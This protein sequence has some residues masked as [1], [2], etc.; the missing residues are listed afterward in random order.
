MAKPQK[1][2]QEE[3]KKEL[4][5]AIPKKRKAEANQKED[6]PQLKRPP[7]PLT[8][9]TLNKVEPARPKA[10]SPEPKKTIPQQI[11][12]LYQLSK[13]PCH[14]ANESNHVLFQTKQKIVTLL[15]D[16]HYQTHQSEIEKQH[17]EFLSKMKEMQSRIDEKRRA[18]MKKME[19][20]SSMDG[21]KGSDD[22]V[23]S[24]QVLQRALLLLREETPKLEES[25]V[26]LMHSKREMERDGDDDCKISLTELEEKNHQGYKLASRVRQ[27][28][29]DIEIYEKC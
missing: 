27:E 20:L 28:D 22:G 29:D 6:G 21:K 4:T 10:P 2:T 7:V 5:K 23:C 26:R 24:T 13:K 19:M 8:S 11:E 9:P 17:N 1:S 15:R 12:E 3:T 25:V 14:D 16:A 18:V